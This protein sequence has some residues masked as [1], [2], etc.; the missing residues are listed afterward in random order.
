[1]NYNNFPNPG[2]F[3]S[4]NQYAPP[5]QNYMPNA[6]EESEDSLDFDLNSINPNAEPW[7]IAQQLSGGTRDINSHHDMHRAFSQVFSP[8]NLN[9]ACRPKTW[10]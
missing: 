5:Q 3:A 1:M 8:K 9:L 4:G 10:T 2:G 7:E 6:C